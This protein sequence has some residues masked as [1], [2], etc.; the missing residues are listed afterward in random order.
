MELNDGINNEVKVKINFGESIEELMS[1]FL[2]FVL[3]GVRFLSSSWIDLEHFFIEK[4]F[5]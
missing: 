3:V 2:G 1:W 4:M 5:F